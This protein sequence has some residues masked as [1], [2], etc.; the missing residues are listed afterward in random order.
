MRKRNESGKGGT[1]AEIYDLAHSG[2]RTGRY[3]RRCLRCQRKAGDALAGE[4]IRA[5]RSDRQYL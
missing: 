5:G 4:K 1:M 3:L 2:R